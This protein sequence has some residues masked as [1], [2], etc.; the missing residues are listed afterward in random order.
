MDR[1]GSMKKSDLSDFGCSLF[2]HISDMGSWACT[3]MD[4][5]EFCYCA[6]CIVMSKAVS[7]CC[8]E[9]MRN[10]GKSESR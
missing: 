2:A 3:A 9:N 7:L 5:S 4:L 10:K 8:C 6:Y 1:L